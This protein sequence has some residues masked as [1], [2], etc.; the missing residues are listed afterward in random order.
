MTENEMVGWHHKLHRHEFE[1]A[2][3]VGDGQGSLV[4]CSPWVSKSQTQLRDRTVTASRLWNDHLGIKV[5]LKDY[6]Q[7]FQW[8]L[9]ALRL[10]RIQPDVQSCTPAGSLPGH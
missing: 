8:W 7:I 6:H 9:T 2:P 4:C 10:Y 1:Q 5:H 3:G